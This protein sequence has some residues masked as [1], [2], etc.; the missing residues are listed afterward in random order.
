M[1]DMNDMNNSIKAIEYDVWSEG[2]T[3]CW[4]NEK[5]DNNDD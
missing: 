5:R 4:L 1:N 3:M 2:A